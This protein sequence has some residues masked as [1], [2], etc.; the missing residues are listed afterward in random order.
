MC[1]GV[2]IS[3]RLHE[4]C[5]NADMTSKLIKEIEDRESSIF[6]ISRL[7]IRSFVFCMIIPL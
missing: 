6:I 7:L 1:E 4:Y 2:Q 5:R 3:V